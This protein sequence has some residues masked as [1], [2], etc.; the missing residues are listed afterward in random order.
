MND[1]YFPNI[2]NGNSEEKKMKDEKFPQVKNIY[3]RDL[4]KRWKKFIYKQ[5]VPLA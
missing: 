3:E 4:I 1:Y 2:I 5:I